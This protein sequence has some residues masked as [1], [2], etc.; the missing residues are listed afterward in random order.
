MTSPE[1]TARAITVEG[2]SLSIRD[3]HLSGID[4]ALSGGEILVILGPN[5]SGKSL[6]LETIAGFHRPAA[7]RVLIGGRDVTQLAPERRNVAFMVQNFGLFPHL[8]V[9]QNVA[10]GLRK[11][12]A[13]PERHAAALPHGDVAGLLD[14]FDIT[15]LAQRAPHSLSAG[16]KQ[17]VALARA[18]AAEPDLFLFD[19][20][21]SALDAHTRDQL[22]EELASFLR[23]LSIPA[24]FVTHDHTDA[25]VLADRII[26]LRGGITVQA[27][28]VQ[29]VFYK[30]ANVF[31]ARFIGVENILAGRIAGSCE[32]LSTVAIGERMLRAAGPQVAS[33]AYVQVGV[34]AEAVSIHSV[35]SASAPG[36]NRF[37]ARVTEVRILGPLATVQIDCGFPLKAYVL[38]QQA[39]DLELIP[40]RTVEA[41]IAPASVRLM[42]D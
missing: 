34:R 17:R 4:F 29:E 16:E 7:G 24:I 38:A 26:V 36:V 12:R 11:R 23:R 20:P 14:Y 30:P 32:A 33:G 8:T 25:M 39:R 2:L 37:V 3:F 6:T 10:V 31:V 21:F 35:G 22:R 19:E 41:E 40:G 28:S 42:F 15:Q 1:T 27:G 5:G 9:R 13:S 18:L